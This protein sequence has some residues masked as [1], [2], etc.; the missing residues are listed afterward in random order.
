M[1]RSP[2]G[3]GFWMRRASRMTRGPVCWRRPYAVKPPMRPTRRGTGVSVA[4]PNASI[5][6]SSWLLGGPTGRSA[7]AQN[8]NCRF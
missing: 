4:S 1:S 6:R 2:T 3:H 5:A 8:L 7:P